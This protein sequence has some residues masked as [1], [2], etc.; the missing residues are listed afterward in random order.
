MSSTAD[1]INPSQENAPL[2]GKSVE[3]LTDLPE[4]G[5]EP[6]K[7]ANLAPMTPFIASSTVV[8][9]LLATGPFT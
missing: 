4:T 7:R 5:E 6:I 9:L 3:P 2:T 1:L 8:N